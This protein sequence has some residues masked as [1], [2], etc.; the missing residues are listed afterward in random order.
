MR[1]GAKV[2]I[3]GG[4][5]L[6]VA[7]GVGYGGYTMLSGGGDDGP[8]PEKILTGPVTPE[9]TDRA[10]GAFLTAWAEGR[11]PE[12]AQLTN[13]PV[14]AEPHVTG[15]RTKAKVS[16]AVIT[17]GTPAG[18]KVPFT[19][20]ATVSF[21]GGSK[22]LSYS[23]ELTVV[24]GRTT[25]R[26][27][28]DWKP[29]V[30]HPRL[31]A[32]TSLLTD[33]SAAPPVRAVDHQGRELTEKKHP[34]LG[35]VLAALREKYGK[36][37]GGTPG[38]ELVISSTREGVADQTLLTLSKGKEG[39]LTTT[40]DA[41]VQ[42]AAERAVKK[43]G[44]ASAVAV[45]P[46]TG[47]I[48]A[49]ANSPASGYNTA[50]LGTQAPGST[51]KIVTAAMML[52]NGAVKGPDSSVECPATVQWAG[53]TFQNLNKFEIEKPTFRQAFQRSCN[54]TFIKAVTPLGE[55]KRDT[56]LAETAS[57]YF[58]IG[59]EWRTG[60]ASFDGSVP[61]STGTETAAS[62]IGQGRITMNALTMASVS[63]TAKN[64]AFKQP[65]L[66]PASL[67]GRE[68]ATADPLPGPVASGLR[69]LMGASTRGEGTGRKAMAAVTGDKGA[70][71]GSAEVDGQGKS[72][73]WFTG[74]A[75]DLAAAAVVQ[76]GGRGGD[77][78]GPVVAKVLNA[79]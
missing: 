75:D 52:D 58:G 26:P 22:P 61:E 64:G 18:P 39:T 53:A 42:A 51:M 76:S 79:R 17:P 16:R 55:G 41:E 59:R 65:V 11:G 66:V 28:V 21:D 38:S 23:S 70:K 62:Y 69:D 8:A 63:A 6:A 47:E 44:Q 4:V 60:V 1:S 13:K 32:T 68:L 36:E 7:G 33:E 19:V 40:L 54:T 2:A 5:F 14:E 24:R 34:S 15:F 9:E 27:L 25:G 31:T 73:S 48:R 67:D 77:A 57:T 12:A 50:M 35:P 3:I 37:A 49:I 46:S 78:A 71:T 56:A 29:S 30:V 20:K 74:Y 43:H 10:A 72:N 45:K